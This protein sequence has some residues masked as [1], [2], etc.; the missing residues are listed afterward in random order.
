MNQRRTEVMSALQS[1]NEAV[2]GVH[3]PVFL[4][5][6]REVW[7]PGQHIALIGP[8]GTGK[9]TFA[10][11]I[12]KLRKYVLAFDP[13]GGDSTL[14]ASGY[15]R[16]STWPPP[17]RIRREIA[18]GKPAHLIVGPVVHTT[19]DR[20]T[21]KEV[22]AQALASAFDEGGWTVY[23]DEFQLLADRRLMGL[24]TESETLLIAARDKGVSVVTAY[25]APA[26]VPTSASRQATW[27]CL[28]PTRDIDVVRKLSEIVGRPRKELQEAIDALPD[29]HTLIIGRNPRAPM[30]ITHAPKVK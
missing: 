6:F 12:L 19:D 30:V 3:W 23:L 25:Q 21:L 14:A 26:W 8:T 15:E 1:E 20:E 22:Q 4:A 13:K 29:H 2:V 18:E 11:G 27:V 17:E 5:W 24:H 9:S 7:E 16:A 10:V 28:W